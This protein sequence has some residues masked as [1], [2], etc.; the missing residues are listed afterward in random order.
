MILRYPPLVRQPGSICPAFTTCM[1]I[2]PTFLELARGIHPNPEPAS[3][4][5]KKAYRGR[6]VFGVRGK[7]WVKYLSSAPS[8]DPY[9]IHG[10]NDRPV[11]WEQHG[12]ASLRQ[13][14]WKVSL[15]PKCSLSRLISRSSTYLLVIRPGPVNG[16]CTIYP[17]IRGRLQT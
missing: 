9:A 8:E 11:G 10:E 15:V 7:S 6:S 16:S 5:D 14:K 2:L 4:R 17:P 3:P 1:D 12:R 13:G